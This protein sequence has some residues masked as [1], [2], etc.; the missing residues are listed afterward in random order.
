MSD[1]LP[2]ARVC[3]IPTDRALRVTTGEHDLAL[4]QLD[5]E[6]Y[7]LENACPH[8]GGPLGEGVVENGCVLCPLHGWAFDLKTGVCA[9]KPNRPAIR[10]PIRVIDGLVFLHAS[11]S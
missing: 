2:L 11:V 5:G 10:V 6:V 3:D 7:A 8:K 4:F 9:D 1:H